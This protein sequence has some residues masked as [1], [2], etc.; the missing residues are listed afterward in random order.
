[1][2]GFSKL[3]CVV[4]LAVETIPAV[5]RAAWLASRT[6]A[7]VELFIC[8]YNEYLSGDRWFDFAS[9]EQARNNALER[10]ERQLEILAMPLRA[11][12]LVVHTAVAWDH[13]QHE[14]IIRRA[15]TIGADVILKSTPHHAVVA[16]T[17]FSNTDWNLIRTSAAALWL[18]KPGSI[19]DEPVLVAAID[20]TNANDKS[21]A[22]DDRI[23]FSAKTLAEAT[24]GRA[25]AFH[26]FDS[27]AAIAVAT[28]NSYVP[29]SL[30]LGEIEREIRV[31]HES[32]FRELTGFHNIDDDK[33]HLVSGPTHVTLP[34]LA[35]KLGASVTIMGAVA[36]NRMNRPYIGATAEQ[37]LEYLPC[38]LLIV[39]PDWVDSPILASPCH[40][41]AGSG[42][43]AAGRR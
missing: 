33:T 25:H 41:S 27:C 26:S 21:A 35:G 9:L 37:T 11:D 43:Q 40:D 7:A 32:R 20:P 31:K 39:R 28:A 38:D 42:D 23:L 2:Q 29:A 22:L 30:P 36:R 17:L 12:G 19:P 15:A 10:L 16:R 5:Q 6:G 3:L 18:V 1:M 24:G 13:P 34:A 14:G 8:L 4:D